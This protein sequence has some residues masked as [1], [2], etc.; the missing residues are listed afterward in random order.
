MMDAESARALRRGCEVIIQVAITDGG[1][2]F[3]ELQFQVGET[4]FGLTPKELLSHPEP[5]VEMPT[6]QHWEPSPTP[7]EW[8]LL[9]QT[10]YDHRADPKVFSTV[11]TESSSSMYEAIILSVDAMKDLSGYDI[12]V[13]SDVLLLFIKSTGGLFLPL[14]F[15]FEDVEF[16]NEISDPENRRV[17]RVLCALC[18]EIVRSS[19]INITLEELL[20][21]IAQAIVS[22]RLEPNEVSEVTKALAVYSQTVNSIEYEMNSEN[23]M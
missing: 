16:L 10:L 7:K 8:K 12:S 18:R 5:Y 13:V 4:S 23:A 20:S 1:V 17:V 2:S 22:R 3:V 14:N 6:S 9:V 19:P 15:L 21:P 11:P